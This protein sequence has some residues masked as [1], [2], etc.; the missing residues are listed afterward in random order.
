MRAVFPNPQDAH[1]FVW[2][3]NE[4]L[5]HRLHVTCVLCWRLPIEGVPFDIYYHLLLFYGEMNTILS[6]L[7]TTVPSFFGSFSFIS[8]AFARTMFI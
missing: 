7:T 8:S 2:V 3:F 5:P 4:A 1:I 6:P